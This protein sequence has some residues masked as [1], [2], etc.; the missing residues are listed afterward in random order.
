MVSKSLDL[1]CKPKSQK[2]QS[3]SLGYM[4]L[5]FGGYPLKRATVYWGY[6]RFDFSLKVKLSKRGVVGILGV[7]IEG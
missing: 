4:S 7:H 3:G 6:V 1:S 5:M 2:A